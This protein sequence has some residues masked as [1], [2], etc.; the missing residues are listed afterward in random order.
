VCEAP[1]C[2]AKGR[3]RGALVE[4]KLKT[5]SKAFCFEEVDSCSRPCLHGPVVCALQQQQ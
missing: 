5:E 4:S 1:F 2:A 3:C